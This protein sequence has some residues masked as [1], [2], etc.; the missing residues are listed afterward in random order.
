[1]SHGKSLAKAWKGPHAASFQYCRL[2][3]VDCF[4]LFVVITIIFAQNSM[5]FPLNS[6]ENSGNTP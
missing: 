3:I 4:R 1:M 5:I 2:H 6:R